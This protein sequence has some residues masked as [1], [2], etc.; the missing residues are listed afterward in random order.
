ML[1]YVKGETTRCSSL[2]LFQKYTCSSRK[3]ELEEKYC[4]HMHKLYIQI[5]VQE[6]DEQ[7]N[8]SL[9]VFPEQIGKT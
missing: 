8:V 1:E 4:T 6:S 5:K 7:K 2:F 3:E 9:R